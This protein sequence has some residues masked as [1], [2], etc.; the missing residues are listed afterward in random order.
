MERVNL[1][2]PDVRANP[3]PYYAEM[4]RSAP[5]CQVD[6]GGLWAVS[7]YDDVAFVLKDNEHFTSQ[8]ARILAVQPWL[9]HNPLVDSMVL[10]DPPIHTKTRALVTKAFGSRVVPR[11][12]PLLRAAA[13]EVLEKI[14]DGHEF[15]FCADYAMRL[16]AEAISNLLGLDPALREKFK[17]WSD[18]LVSVGPAA[19]PEMIESIKRTVADLEGYLRGVIAARRVEPRDDLVSDLLA[20]E[21]DGVS[22]TA[23]EIVS[24]LFLL[25]LSGLETTIHLLALS[26][27]LLIKHPDVAARVRQNPALTPN[28]VEEVLRFEPPSQSVLRMTRHEVEIG[29]VKVPSGAIVVALLGSANRDESVF[30]DGDRFDIDRQR[31]VGMPFGQGIHFCLGAALARA[32]AKIGLEALLSLPGRF[33]SVR[34]D[35]EWNISLTVRGPKACWVRY[36][37]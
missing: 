8:G 28:L 25:F 2:A 36:R 12:E 10:M 17:R 15:D 19:T 14:K 21:I 27:L 7:R 1:F 13:G 18:D 35:V 26:L 37:E 33:E 3:Y 23:A 11:I 24:F 5:V 4:R 16:P 30:P 31:Q 22:L 34:G 6:P 20:S 9:P 32:E 29:G